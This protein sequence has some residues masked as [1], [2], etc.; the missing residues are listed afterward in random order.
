M[1]EKVAVLEDEK[2]ILDLISLH[3]EKA[4]FTVSKFSTAD[5]FFKSFSRESFSL[6]ILDLILPDMDGIDVCRQVK[7][8]PGS[9]SMPVIM[10]TAKT[11][12][13]DKVVGLEMGADDYV[14][15][16]FS[17]RELVARARSV[18]RR[19]SRQGGDEKIYIGNEISIDTGKRQVLVEGRIAELTFAEYG[20]LFILA[21]KKGWVFSREKIIDT[22][23][24]GE[25][26]VIERT[27]DVHV[28][29]LRTKLGNGKK[30]IKNVRGIGYKIEE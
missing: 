27:V 25:K 26:A 13:S 9:S 8:N 4:G 18:L 21:S 6:L 15:K 2:D 24:D 3:L 23:W 16:P 1:K 29:N 5:D 28:K 22:L 17:P 11:E 20:I 12:L 30:Y 14:T 10:V 7:N 19:Y